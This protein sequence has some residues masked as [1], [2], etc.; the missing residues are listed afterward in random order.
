MT[1]LSIDRWTWQ[2]PLA[3]AVI[4]ADGWP[5]Y[6]FVLAADVTV[7]QLVNFEILRDSDAQPLTARAL[8]RVPLGALEDALYEELESFIDQWHADNPGSGLAAPRP[9]RVR[10]NRDDVK[11]AELAR[12]YV[13]T[14]G[15]PFQ[16]RRLAEDFGFNYSLA[17]IPKLIARARQRGL[18]TPTTK[19]R[20]GGRLTPKA[21]ALL[22][23]DA[24]EDL[25]AWDRASRDQKVAAMLREA[26]HQRLTEE[27]H[28]RRDELGDMFGPSLLALDALMYGSEPDDEM[29]PDQD[30]DAIKRAAE[31]LR[32]TYPELQP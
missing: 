15:Q 17:T 1:E 14:L 28:A 7:R 25:S 31:Q 9:E 29:Y 32:H 26:Q 6:R 27:L 23:G 21:I 22:G 5:G 19:G 16:M 18:L 13:E 3:G 2:P 30:L 20:S 24:V 10:A 4:C 12:A 11:L 8:A